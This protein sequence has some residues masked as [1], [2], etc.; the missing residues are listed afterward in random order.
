MFENVDGALKFVELFLERSVTTSDKN[1]VRLDKPIIAM[2]GSLQ[3]GL[4]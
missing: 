3:D 2:E 1:F 4:K